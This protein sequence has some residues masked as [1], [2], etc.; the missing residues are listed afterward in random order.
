MRQLS[1]VASVSWI[2]LCAGLSSHGA[3]ATSFQDWQFTNNINPAAPTVVT[4]SAGVPTA[5]MVIG[6]AGAGWLYSLPGFGTQTGMW[7]IGS[8]NP[9]DPTNDT[10][11]QV[12]LAIPN[13]LPPSGGSYTDLKLRVV[14]YV[15]GGIYSG[16]LTFSTTGAVYGGRTIVEPSVGLN[17]DWVEDQY[18]WHLV[19]GPA[20][21]SLVITGAVGGTLLDRIRVDTDTAPAPP[22]IVINSVV[23]TNQA[24][25]ISWMGGFPPYQVYVTSNLLSSGSWQ[26]SGAPVSGTNAQVPLDL[27]TGF[28][29]VLGSSQ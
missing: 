28:V 27:A 11:G 13:P 26:P 3:D 10:R 25:A 24:L 12:W 23:K 16:D 20:Q 21:I 6:S 1:G 4:N 8:Q 17:G 15:D 2:C 7:D 29:R 14:Q 5:T 22:Q 18:Q 9:Q 19:P